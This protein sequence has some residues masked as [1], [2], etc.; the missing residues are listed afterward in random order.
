MPVVLQVNKKK[1]YQQKTLPVHAEDI[2]AS[3]I[4]LHKL[5]FIK[6]PFEPTNKRKPKK[7]KGLKQNIQWRITT[8]T[9]VSKNYRVKGTFRKIV[10]RT[11]EKKVG[12]Y[13]AKQ[14]YKKMKKKKYKTSARNLMQSEKAP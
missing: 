12:T 7:K 8:T 13:E 14:E 10:R 5:S 9:W 4:M 3:K 6:P 1:K 2:Y 11:T